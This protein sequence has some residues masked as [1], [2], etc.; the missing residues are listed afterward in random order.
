VYA[1]EITRQMV[2]DAWEYIGQPDTFGTWFDE[3]KGRS[4]MERVTL[5]ETR[6][7]AITRAGREGSRYVFDLE[8]RTV[9]K[10]A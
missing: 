1:R 9:E 3:A 8:A 5:H 4:I 10:A 7:E 2:L 6:E